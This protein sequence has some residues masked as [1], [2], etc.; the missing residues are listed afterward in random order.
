MK[1]HCKKLKTLNWLETTA[2]FRRQFKTF[3]YCHCGSGM[4]I[5]V[6]VVVV[7]VA[8][9]VVMV[10]LVVVVV[11]VVVL[12][13]VVVVVVVAAWPKC[14]MNETHQTSPNHL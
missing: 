10:A 4:D 9:V 6:V 8:M 12:V 13:A 7:E 3:Q 1:A 2:G 11:A 5:V 14:R